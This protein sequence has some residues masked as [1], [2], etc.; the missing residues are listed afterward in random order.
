MTV[1]G[2]G[3]MEFIFILKKKGFPTFYMKYFGNM[4]NK[5]KYFL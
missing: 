5:I 1:E 2:Q 4:T 3:H